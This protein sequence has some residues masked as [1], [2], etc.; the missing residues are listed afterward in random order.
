MAI[1]QLGIDFYPDLRLHQ[2]KCASSSSLL[3]IV[4]AYIRLISRLA[5][6]GSS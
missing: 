5:V 1:L 4:N 3:A 2:D 6:S